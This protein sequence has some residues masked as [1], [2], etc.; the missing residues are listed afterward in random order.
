MGNRTYLSVQNAGSVQS[1]YDDVAFETNNF[2]APLWFSLMSEEQYQQYR[3]RLLT[4]WEAYKSKIDQDNAE[5]LPEAAAFYKA[6]DWSISWKEGSAQMQRC[7][8]PI[9]EHFPM[10]ASYMSAWHETLLTHTDS[11]ESPVILL[12]LSQFFSFYEEPLEYLEAIESCLQLWHDPGNSWF[13]S[14]QQQMDSYILGGEH[15]P[16]GGTQVN[17]S[18]AKDFPASPPKPPIS[19]VTEKA[20]KEDKG[21]GPRRRSS[22]SK[23][24]QKILIWVLAILSAALALGAYWLT[25]NGWLTF[26]AFLLPSIGYIGRKL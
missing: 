14:Q 8:P 12:E 18:G 9:I 13:A 6:L 5:E 17:D 23:K 24:R 7:V 1:S 26:I 4:S 25:D 19:K 3:S 20:K 15:L 2:I 10:L 22:R 16:R 11:Y 21:L